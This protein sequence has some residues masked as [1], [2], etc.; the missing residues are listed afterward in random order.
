MSLGDAK[1]PEKKARKNAEKRL[2]YKIGNLPH[3]GEADLAENEYTFPILISLPRVIFDETPE[4]SK[5]VDVKFLDDAKVGEICVDIQSGDVTRQTNRSA[6]EENIRKK[7][8]ELEEEVQ[9]ALVKSAANKL[10]LLSYG[11]H[12]NMP[13]IEILSEVIIS[14]ELEL[15]KLESLKKDYP[16]HLER[17][18]QANLV[19]TSEGCV[20]PDNKL[21]NI[22]NNKGSPSDRLNDALAHLF[23]ENANNLG[24]M[25]D[26][27]GPALDLAGYYYRRA[28]DSDSLPKVTMEEFRRKMAQK[29]DDKAFQTSRIVMQLENVGILQIENKH[30]ERA[31]SGDE[32]IREDVMEQ[33]RDF[34]TIATAWA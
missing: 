11:R 13:A 6:V 4:G 15:D 29:G 10:C 27:L 20:V 2:R 9:K 34:N 33:A 24:Y 3:L 32:G 25:S 8:Q 5:P 16:T 31:W 1:Y 26:W 21:K 28:I 12:K 18:V 30:G 23:E 17:L 22:I 7:K 14:G 19:K